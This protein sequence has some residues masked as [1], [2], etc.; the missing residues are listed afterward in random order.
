MLHLNDEG[1]VC[2]CMYKWAVS[3]NNVVIAWTLLC[4]LAGVAPLPQARQRH[5][6]PKGNISLTATP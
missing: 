5:V 4:P 1:L 2:L 3:V 6:E